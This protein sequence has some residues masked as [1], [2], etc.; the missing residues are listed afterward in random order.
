MNLEKNMVDTL[1]AA[2]NV[3]AWFG[4]QPQSDDEAPSEMPVIIV[5][6]PD[7]DWLNDFSGVDVDLAVTTIQVDYY[8]ET[9]EA[10]RRLADAGRLAVRDLVDQ[11]D[12]PICPAL[13]TETSF[14]D[15]V[16]RAWRVM[17]QWR[18]PDYNPSLPV[19]TP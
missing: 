18:V 15:Q 1:A 13:S 7:A 19:P 17:Q 4:A 2:C 14:Y 9:A 12:D 6:R 16:S 8:A 10:A 3:P 11:D 5:N